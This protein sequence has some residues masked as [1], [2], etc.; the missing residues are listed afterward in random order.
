MT[1]AIP[2]CA[3]GILEALEAAGY[4]S[5]AVGGCVRD[6]MLGLTPHDWDVCTAARP[7][8]IEAVFAGK[9]VI[10][11]G[12]AHGTVTVLFDGCPV[13]I[14]TFRS[15]GEYSDGRRPDGVTFVDD[16]HEDLLR[17]DFTVN[18]MAYSPTRGLRDDFGG[19]EDLSAR[20]LRCVGCADDRLREDSLRILRGLRF[21][22]RYGLA[23]DPETDRSLRENRRLLSNVS[24]ERIFAELKGILTAPGAGA[25]ML[26]YPEI[27]F[28]VFP[29]MAPM[30]GFDQHLPGV[31]QYDVWGHTACAVD[32]APPD[33]AVRLT[34]FFHDCGKPA[35][36]FLDPETGRGRFYGHPEAGAETADALLRRLR[37]D[38]ALRET[39]TELIRCH[40]HHAGQ[41]RK[42]LRRLLSRL[43][44]ERMR[45]LFSV[46]RADAAAHTP[47]TF[48]KRLPLIEQEERVFEELLSEGSCRSVRDL[49]VGGRDLLALGAAPGPALGAVLQSLLDE[50]MDEQLPN[51]R[52]ALL[53][54]AEQLM[55]TAA[56][57]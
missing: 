18:A 2:P 3:A 4:E 14:T 1:I 50:V 27:F 16:V 36:F 26:A 56:D 8:Q 21:A 37:S 41:T 29:E 31:H 40:S 23:A 20:R 45:L 34:M 38:N 7:D 13:E 39:V 9:R 30:L 43:G 24:A 15:D 42:A 28:A 35:T 6:A 11:T 54:R 49:A 57:A 53:R 17:R 48:Q 46:W 52:D 47:Q 32:A 10:A 12:I 55:A 19:Q 44:E 25:V 33:T 22:A 5:Y 51:E